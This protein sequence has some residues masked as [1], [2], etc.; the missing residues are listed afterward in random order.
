MSRG[1]KGR[2]PDEIRRDRAE[3]SR[4][5]LQRW[6]QAGIGE[7][8]GLSRQQ[9][10]YDLEAIRQEWLA[11]AVMDFNARKAEELARIDRVEAEAWAAWEKSKNGREIAT[12][13]QTGG[14]GDRTRAATRKEEQQGDPRYL[15]CVQWCVEKRCRLLGLNAPTETRL[16]GKDGGPIRTATEVTTQIDVFARVEQ[17]HALLCQLEHGDH[18]GTAG[19]DALAGPSEDEGVPASTVPGDR[20]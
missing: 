14:D 18:P 10:G 1:R 3:I 4:L 9:I 19:A 8:L 5:Y 15:A 12:P 20:L 11:S 16:T 17:Y 13:E 6:T 7:R 2:S